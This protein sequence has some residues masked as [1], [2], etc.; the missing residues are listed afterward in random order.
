[1]RSRRRER[2]LARRGRP[3]DS[4]SA[5]SSCI[6]RGVVKED[7]LEQA[8]ILADAFEAVVGAIYLERGYGTARAFVQ[9]CSF[10]TTID[11]AAN[12]PDDF[13]PKSRLQEMGRPRGSSGTPYT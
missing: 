8:S 13:D 11:R 2:R 3:S 6:G 10:A 12:E 7:G 1:M 4:A 5:R 9:S